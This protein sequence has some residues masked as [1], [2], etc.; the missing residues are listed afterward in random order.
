MNSNQCALT[1]PGKGR[2]CWSDWI[3]GNPTS[4]IIDKYSTE[5]EIGSGHIRSIGETAAWM[6]NTAARIVSVPD[7]SI[8][9]EAAPRVLEDLAKRCKFG[10][11]SEVVSIAEL[12]VL[13]RSELNLLVHNSAG[14]I[15]DTR[16]KNLGYAIERVRWHSLPSKGTIFEICHSCPN[17]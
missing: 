17:R 8:D 13:Q 2:E 9:D 14:K 10:V 11:P 1:A 12:R 7:G 15:L 4:Q 5:Y 6:L 16:H 3:A